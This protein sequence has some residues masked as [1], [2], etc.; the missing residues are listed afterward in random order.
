MQQ[1]ALKAKIELKKHYIELS[2]LLS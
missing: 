2:K 1:N